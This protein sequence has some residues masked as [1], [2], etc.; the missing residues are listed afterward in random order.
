MPPVRTGTQPSRPAHG[1]LMWVSPLQYGPHWR[2]VAVVL[3][4]SRRSAAITGG[5]ALKLF[6]A[7]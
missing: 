4:G 2:F 7:V 5:L 6:L 3:N 1:D